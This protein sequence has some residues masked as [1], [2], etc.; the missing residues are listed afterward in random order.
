MLL[1]HRL[2]LYEDKNS[3][4]VTATLEL[5]GMKKE[6]ISIDVHQEQLTITGE[7][8][9]D[10]EVKDGAYT[11]RERKFGKFTRSIKL[12]KGTKASFSPRFYLN[13]I[14]ASHRR[15]M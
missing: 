12:P 5:P 13:F 4:L 11:L 3:N 8:E 9:A 10:S 6:D 2:D 1:F 14:N 7:A 15:K